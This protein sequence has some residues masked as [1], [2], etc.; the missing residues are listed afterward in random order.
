MGP[1]KRPDDAPR[2]LCRLVVYVRFLTMS[3]VDPNWSTIR[4]C[5]SSRLVCAPCIIHQVF[6]PTGKKYFPFPCFLLFVRPGFHGSSGMGCRTYG[7]KGSREA[8][9]VILRVARDPTTPGGVGPVSRGLAGPGTVERAWPVAKGPCA[10][11][12]RWRWTDE[13][14]S[15]GRAA[16]KGKPRLEGFVDYSDVARARPP[17]ARARPPGA[18]GRGAG[19]NGRVEP[20]PDL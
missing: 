15:E 19:R 18:R 11:R 1:V 10:G 16:K 20:L 13:P 9:G 7:A 17:V 8:L 5:R 14:E 6:A 2:L 3:E 12:R 4:Y